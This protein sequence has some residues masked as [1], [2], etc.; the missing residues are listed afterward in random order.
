MADHEKDKIYCIYVDEGISPEEANV[1]HIIPLSLGG[2]NSFKIQVSKS[3]N[4]SVGSLLDGVLSKDFLIQAVR[5]KKGYKGHSK[6][7]AKLAIRGTRTDTGEKVVVYYKD[8]ENYIFNP[9]KNLRYT[10][11]EKGQIPLALTVQFNK[12]V[13]IRFVAKVAL[14]AG[15]F[16]FG[17]KFR[18]HTDHNS[19]RRIMNWE[20]QGTTDDDIPVGLLDEFREIPEDSPSWEATFRVLFGK[21]GCSGVAFV[22]GPNQII[23]AVGIGG[24]FIGSINFKADG[25]HFGYKEGPYDGVVVGLQNKKIIKNSFHKLLKRIIDGFE[26]S[27]KAKAPDMV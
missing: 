17:D 9:V 19:L 21:I 11:D 18:Q 8:G 5:R 14:S 13:R 7:P 20:V 6:K 27:D 16:L 24:R 4:A 1:E 22:L 3:K 26:K 10:E 25:Q 2:I 12:N 15:Y 23:A